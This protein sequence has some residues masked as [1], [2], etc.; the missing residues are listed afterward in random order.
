VELPVGAS[1]CLFTD[2]LVE[3]R[4]SVNA[5]DGDQIDEGLAHL[6]DALRP[7]SADTA[8]T[9]VLTELVGEGIT[10]DDIALLVLRRLPA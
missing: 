9:T 8:C 2:G 10:E 7:G 1:L 3:R 4:P 6:R 5:V